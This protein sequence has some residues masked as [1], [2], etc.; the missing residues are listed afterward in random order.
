M[1]AA[2]TLL[3]GG[4]RALSFFLGAI[5][6]A[7]A[8]ALALG[9][10]EPGQILAWAARVL[11]LVFM[12]LLSVLILTTLYCWQRLL[13]RDLNPQQRQ[14]WH[15]A[16]LHAA[17]GVATLALTYTLFGISLGI[18]ELAGQS[19]TPDTVQEVIRGLTER[20]SLAFMTTVIGLPTSALLRA[21]LSISAA[22]I[23]A[24]TT[25]K[26]GVLPCGS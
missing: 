11:G 23:E 3:G 4:S 20:F 2:I 6:L 24:K 7:L 8:L 14:A 15:E 9:A 21:L 26:G 25:D 10:P 16:G 22:W 17:N 18:G 1:A 5:V 12:G 13:V 19:L